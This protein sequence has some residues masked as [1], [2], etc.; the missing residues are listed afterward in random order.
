M[1]GDATEDGDAVQMAALQVLSPEQRSELARWP[2]GLR[3]VHS[4]TCATNEQ[5]SIRQEAAHTYEHLYLNAAD[6]D[7]LTVDT[8]AAY[9][10]VP[11]WRFYTLVSDRTLAIRIFGAVHFAPS[12]SSSSQPSYGFHAIALSKEGGLRDVLNAIPMNE[13]EA[14]PRWEQAHLDAI[15]SSRMSA[16]FLDPFGWILCVK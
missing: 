1:S 7:E 4:S 14:L 12:D 6:A 10:K 2:I 16:H 8:A 3:T 9:S 5:L 15:D 13:L 11:R